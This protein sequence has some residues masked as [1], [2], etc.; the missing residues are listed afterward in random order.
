M[1]R[2]IA[3]L[4]LALFILTI[5]GCGN[6]NNNNN[7]AVAPAAPKESETKKQAETSLPLKIGVMRGAQSFPIAAMQK[8]GIDKKYGLQL[9]I[10]PL[11]NDSAIHTAIMSNKVDIVF[12]TWQSYAVQRNRGEDEVVIAP[13]NYMV[14]DV[15]VRKD[16]KINSMKDLRG[17]K[18]GTASPPGNGAS[19]AFQYAVQKEFGFDPYKE[20]ALTQGATP[21]LLGL[22]EKG[23]IDAFYMGEPQLTSARLSGNFKSIWNITQAYKNINERLPLQVIVVTTEASLKKSNEAIKRFAKAY[24]ESK[25]VLV[26]DN[27]IWPELAKQV[28]VES[29]QGANMLRESLQPYYVQEWNKDMIDKEIEQG[30]KMKQLFK[31]SDFLPDKIPEVLFSF[32]IYNK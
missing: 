3:L 22:L 20:N 19:L 28:G 2:I 11:A 31:A 1:R 5:G 4:T 10:T 32:D 30:Y 8:N 26:K 15:I 6:N 21:L 9:E 18:L 12:S 16:S 23:E 13:V 7:K 24:A 17:K 27:Q 14:K 29:E 25:D